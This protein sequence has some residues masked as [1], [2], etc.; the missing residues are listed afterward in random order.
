MLDLK[1]FGLM[2]EEIKVF[3]EEIEEAEALL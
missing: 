1:E 2:D 3:N